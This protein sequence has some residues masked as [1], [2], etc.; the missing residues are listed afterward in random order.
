MEKGFHEL[1]ESVA[2][3]GPLRDLQCKK[4]LSKYLF[5]AKN[6]VQKEKGL[7]LR[8]KPHQKDF[9]ESPIPPRMKNH[10]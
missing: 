1:K 5:C 8:A 9:L 4:D 7:D 10:A 3:N 2:E 6:G